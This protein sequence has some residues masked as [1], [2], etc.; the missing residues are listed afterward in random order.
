MNVRVA[1]RWLLRCA[2]ACC[3]VAP[4]SGLVE[5]LRGRMEVTEQSGVAALGMRRNPP[6]RF[7]CVRVHQLHSE[8]WSLSPLC[9]FL[10]CSCGAPRSAR[11]T[12]AAAEWLEKAN[13]IHRTVRRGSADTP[14]SWLRSS[15]ICGM[16][17]REDIACAGTNASS[18]DDRCSER[19]AKHPSGRRNPQSNR[20]GAS[21]PAVDGKGTRGDRDGEGAGST[22]RSNSR[23]R[24]R[25]MRDARSQ[26]QSMI[27]HCGDSE[28]NRILQN[29]QI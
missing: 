25:G 28:T 6:S 16:D 18:T 2:S 29:S 20:D 19:G 23:Q 24:G 9:A 4:S 1:R 21:G 12:A 22:G 11:P 27:R 10:H 17:G 26:P 7:V 5:S 13:R 8:S 14:A 3:A 15:S